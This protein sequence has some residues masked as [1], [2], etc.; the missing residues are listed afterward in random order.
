MAAIISIS[1]ITSFG[2]VLTAKAALAG[3]SCLKYLP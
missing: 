3:G 1:T 2:S